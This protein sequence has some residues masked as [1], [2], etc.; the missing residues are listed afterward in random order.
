MKEDT[1]PRQRRESK[2][3]KW[4]IASYV[5]SFIIWVFLCSASRAK[6]INLDA[7]ESIG[8]VMLVALCL[9]LEGW[10]KR[11]RE[12]QEAVRLLANLRK[13]RLEH[14]LTQQME[15]LLQLASREGFCDAADWIQQTFWQL[16]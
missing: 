9:T 8:C 1:L 3:N 5:L 12:E 7:I 2:E 6:M 16:K 4:F 14:S 13:K 10:K 11:F 15:E